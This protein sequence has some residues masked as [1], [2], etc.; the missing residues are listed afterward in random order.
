M[1]CN[2]VTV[3]VTVA[4]WAI[5]PVGGALPEAI[6]LPVLEVVSYNLL[7]PSDA[8]TSFPKVPGV[9]PACSSPLPVLVIVQV[10]PVSYSDAGE[11]LAEDCVFKV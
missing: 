7:T 1:F 9:V 4:L 3:V 8:Y 11:L 2:P 6:I 5:S 10:I